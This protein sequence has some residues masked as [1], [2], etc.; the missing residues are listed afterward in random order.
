MVLEMRLNHYKKAMG[1]LSR[2]G[3]CG[4]GRA[5]DVLGRMSIAK[6]LRE[7]AGSR[8]TTYGCGVADD[9]VSASA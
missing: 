5:D 3:G 2:V 6:T 9:R 8:R 4:I 7:L 1:E